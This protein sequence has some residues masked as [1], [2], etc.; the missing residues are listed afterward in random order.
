MGIFLIYFLSIITVFIVSIIINKNN[1]STQMSEHFIMELGPYIKPSFKNTLYYSISNV[2]A[3]VVK[4]GTVIFLA[5]IL[6]WFL[7]N[8]GFTSKGFGLVYQEKSLLAE[9]GKKLA[10]FFSPLG[11]GSWQAV[12]ATISGLLAKENV[13]NSFAVILKSAENLTDGFDFNKILTKF[14]MEIF[15][16]CHF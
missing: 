15:L 5:S 4:A 2:K 8:F 3:F 7:L 1:K 16:L 14:L 11:F 12:V 9:F 6:I 13:V 10:I